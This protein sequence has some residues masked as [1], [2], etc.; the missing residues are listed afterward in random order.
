MCVASYGVMPQTY[1]RA[2][3]PGVSG[4]R[5]A[6]AVSHTRTGRPTPGRAGM[7]GEGQAFTA[8]AETGA[9]RPLTAVAT[10][11]R[12]SGAPGRGSGPGAADRRPGPAGPAP[13]PAPA[14]RRGP[15]PGCWTVHPGR[16]SVRPG[17]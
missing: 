10:V 3:G 13:P 4:R 7:N 15:A 9:G 8:G 2:T 1:I 14:A 5:E 12:A 11:R 6:E 16:W 17:G